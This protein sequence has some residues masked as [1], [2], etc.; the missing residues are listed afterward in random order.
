MKENVSSF[1]GITIQIFLLRLGLCIQKLMWRFDSSSFNLSAPCNNHTCQE[2][3][4]AVYVTLK[5][6]NELLI[7]KFKPSRNST[8]ICLEYILAVEVSACLN[9][10]E[11]NDIF[12]VKLKLHNAAVQSLHISNIQT[13]QRWVGI[14]WPCKHS[15]S[16]RNNLW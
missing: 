1:V 14:E 15:F 2:Q 5:I 16:R 13:K 10:S 8:V 11:I 7:L 6:N 12:L 4:G 3:E 9:N